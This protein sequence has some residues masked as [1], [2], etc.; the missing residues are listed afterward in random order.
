MTNRFVRTS[1][2]LAPDHWMARQL[3]AG[4]SLRAYGEDE[5]ISNITNAVQVAIDETGL[6]RAEIARLL[7][8]TKSYVSQVLN[9]STNM[10]LKTLGALLWACGR[11]VTELHTGILADEHHT[12]A[13]SYQAVFVMQ[14]GGGVAFW[15]GSVTSI[16]VENTYTK[17]AAS[18]A[19]TYWA[20]T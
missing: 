15:D 12:R 2:D 20:E 6:T 5:A 18:H 3:P 19:G 1:D 17:A 16:A 4:V 7:G 13:P 8:T 9:G 14:S 10:T 11:Q